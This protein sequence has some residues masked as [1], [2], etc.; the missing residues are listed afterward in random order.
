MWLDDLNELVATLRRRIANH[1]DLLRKSEWATRYALIDPL[2]EALGWD[3]HDPSQVVPEDLGGEGRPDYTLLAGAAGSTP[4]LLI[5]AKKLGTPLDSTLAQAITYCNA[6]GVKHFAVTDGER[7]S[8]YET[9]K[10]VPNSDK[11]RTTFSLPMSD[12]ELVMKLLW[13]WR[14]NF[15]AGKPS[16]P[17]EPPAPA[18]ED[19]DGNGP[20]PQPDGEW[21]PLTDFDPPVRTSA[22]SKIRFPGGAVLAV[23]RWHD[24]QVNVVRWLQETKKLGPSDCPVRSARGGEL[25]STRGVRSDGKRFLRPLPV[26][27]LYVEANRS[28]LDHTR[29]AR[30]ILRA[31]DVDPATVYVLPRSS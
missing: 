26:G 3:T 23:T 21:T 28:A 8:I 1:G 7:W 2:L 14:G 15:V 20:P 29:A 6:R 11:L 10:P 30:R 9:F 12:N 18:E 22:P 19:A 13:L 16:G 24:L 27:G 4:V 25:V 31:R 5:E 17:V